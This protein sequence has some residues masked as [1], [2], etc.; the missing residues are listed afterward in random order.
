MAIIPTEEENYVHWYDLGHVNN[1]TYRADVYDLGPDKTI[2]L[3]HEIQKV[4]YASGLGDEVEGFPQFGDGNLAY[5]YTN[6]SLMAGVEKSRFTILAEKPDCTVT[7]SQDAAQPNHYCDTGYNL[8]IYKCFWQDCIPPPTLPPTLSPNQDDCKWSDASCWED[9]IPPSGVNITIK[10]NVRMIVDVADIDVD[11]VFV[12]GG[13]VFDPT[14]DNLNYNFKARQIIS[15][16]G[17]GQDGFEDWVGARSGEGIVNNWQSVAA[18]K[19]GRTYT[20][21]SQSSIIIGSEVEPWPCEGQVNIE[22]TGDKWSKEVGSPEGAVVIG[23]KAIAAL[24]G[25]EMHGCPIAM[26]KTFLKTSVLKGQNQIT[27]EDEPVGWKVGGRIFIASSSFEMRESEEFLITAIEGNTLTL[28]SSTQFPHYGVDESNTNYEGWGVTHFAASVGYLTRNI[29]ID[30]SADAEDVFGGRIVVMRSKEEANNI[31]RFGYVQLSNVELT[32]MGQFGY[33]EEEDRRGAVFIWGL[34]DATFQDTTLNIK[35]SFIKDCAF[36]KLY[37]TAVGSSATTKLEVSGNVIYNTVD[38]AIVLNGASNSIV[39]NNLIARVVYSNLHKATGCTFCGVQQVEDMVPA[40]IW[41]DTQDYEMTGNI[42]AGTDG[43]CYKVPGKE[44]DTSEQ[45]SSSL[46]TSINLATAN[47]AH[48]CIRG[49][50]NMASIGTCGRFDNFIVYKTIDF[51]F[52]IMT[53]AVT[54]VENSLLVNNWVGIYSWNLGSSALAHDRNPRRNTYKNLRIDQFNANSMQCDEYTRRARAEIV[55]SGMTPNSRVPFTTTNRGSFG[56]L[57]PDY[58]QKKHKWPVK[59]ILF[60]ET[61][62]SLLGGTCVYD[63]E[64]LNFG[65][66][67][68]R[69]HAAIGTNSKWVDHKHK[70]EL[71]GCSYA[72]DADYMYQYA[73]PKLE[74]INLAECVDMD[75]DGL[76]RAMVI[77]VDGSMTGTA[78]TALVAQSEYHYERWVEQEPHYYLGR[79]NVP[80][81]EDFEFSSPQRG[82]GDFRMPKSMVTALDG[83]RIPYSTYAEKVGTIRDFDECEWQPRQNGYKCPNKKMATLLLESYD[84]D[85]ETRRFAPVAI[86]ENGQKLIDIG[87]GVIDHS[88]CFGYSCQLRLAMHY[89]NVECGKTYEYHA[90]GTVPKHARFHLLGLDSINDDCQIRVDF[91]VARQTRQ[92]VYLNDIYQSSNQE[93]GDGT[94]KQ[95]NDNLKPDVTDAAGANYFQRMEQVVY[96]NIDAGSYVDIKSANTIV[97][98]LDVVTELTVDDFW[99]DDGLAEKLAVMLGIDE[100]K[101]KKMNVISESSSRTL[102]AQKAAIF[103]RQTKGKKGKQRSG[104]NVFVQFEIA[105]NW[106]TPAGLNNAGRNDEQAEIDFIAQVANTIVEK[107]DAGTIDDELEQ[108][109]ATVAMGMPPKEAETPEWYDDETNEAK[110]GSTIADE[111]GLDPDDPELTLEEVVQVFEEVTETKIEEVETYNEV[112]ERIEE[113]VDAQDDMIVYSPIDPVYIGMET[114]LRVDHSWEDGIPITPP[115]V[116]FAYNAEDIKIEA[117][118]KNPLDPWRVAVDIAASSPNMTLD[119][120]LECSFSALGKCSFDNLIINGSGDIKLSFNISYQA[121]DTTEIDDLDTEKLVVITTTTVAPPTTQA[122]TQATTQGTGPTVDPTDE[123]T[124]VVPSSTWAP[125][126]GFPSTTTTEVDKD[127]DCVIKKKKQLICADRNLVTGRN[128]AIQ[129]MRL[130]KKSRAKIKSLD[131]SSNPN[132]HQS[133][134]QSILRQLPGLTSLKVLFKTFSGN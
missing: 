24:G 100:S 60:A 80:N 55:T 66:N 67:C 12:E 115:V 36:H 105:Q 56:L 134:L 88:C 11:L 121:G 93:N 14:G 38:D 74:T 127:M 85:R 37:N 109:V 99:D 108:N 10:Q 95:P 133:T 22:L 77:D 50:D 103:R 132:F 87:N 112:Q 23:A 30:G 130:S 125:T 124:T 3:S 29:K 101:I 25:L 39:N 15:N 102:E 131:V 40:G 81:N 91:F 58:T 65:V 42:V 61:Y 113:E 43:A 47:R 86:R 57:T 5:S 97:L 2:R 98:E 27:L 111:V 13:L 110:P 52:F 18:S 107:V 104:N 28:D 20:L 33:R 26:T 44:C 54:V 35:R 21:M 62:A 82:L 4:D 45:C 129:I 49:V 123:P 94:W 84:H 128:L 120:D 71:N 78:M 46:Q 16:T 8:R 126:T 59:N 63:T 73:R 69:G 72:G 19:T 75:C 90:T 53:S 89:F 6:E 41:L 79:S 68:N 92:K 70:L 1:M 119:G 31:A 64:F 7:G 9:G 17:A 106:D 32:H 118:I 117:P 114:D 116:I 83:S 34:E 76:K 51:G 122:T 48:S 96:F